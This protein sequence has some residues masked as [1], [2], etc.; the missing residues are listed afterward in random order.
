[1]F[2]QKVNKFLNLY[3]SSFRKE[4]NEME[5]ILSK[6][7]SQIRIGEGKNSSLHTITFEVDASSSNP[8]EKRFLESIYLSPSVEVI[9]Q[10]SGKAKLRIT[11]SENP[12]R[13]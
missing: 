12:V 8:E 1:V 5:V 7:A 9:D 4:G 10:N 13:K 2:V 11:L 3:Y 6:K